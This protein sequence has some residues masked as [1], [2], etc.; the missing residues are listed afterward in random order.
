MKADAVYHEGKH[1]FYT[2]CWVKN[3]V[4]IHREKTTAD[5]EKNT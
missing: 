2:G 1:E 5:L 3:K 4:Q